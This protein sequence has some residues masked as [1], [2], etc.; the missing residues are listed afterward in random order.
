MDAA[1]LPDGFEAWPA[2]IQQRFME[3]YHA[4]YFPKLR[5][6][7]KPETDEEDSGPRPKQLPPD[8]PRHCLPDNRGYRCGCPHGI[9]D[10]LEC[11]PC[12]GNPEWAIWLN[13]TGR[14]TGKTTRRVGVDDRDGPVQAG[15]PRRRLRPHL[16]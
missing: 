6:W 15:H 2:E 7:Q 9:P 13:L 10:C 12:P 16:R 3:E 4:L 14:G 11:P 5:W 1:D 8:D